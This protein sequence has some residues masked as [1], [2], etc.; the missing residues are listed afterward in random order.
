MEFIKAISESAAPSTLV[1]RRTA[2][3]HYLTYRNTVKR[4][5]SPI[6]PTQLT[7]CLFLI[8]LFQRG[9]TYGTVK[10]YMFSLASELKIRGG[11]NI[12]EPFDSWFI[13]ATLK[14]YRIKIGNKPIRYRRPL[15][16]EVLVSL[17][18]SLDFSIFDNR[19]YGTMA[20]IGF[21]G[22]LRIG[23][24]CFMRVNGVEKSIRMFPVLEVLV[25]SFF[26][27][28]RLT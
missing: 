9:L 10:S 11:K 3:N 1:K 24:L 26:I 17:V 8:Y 22:L 16:T 25:R 23:E 21:Y 7:I 14:H 12:L 15:T 13:R 27:V 5:D 28:Q 4:R 6:C 20:V 2:W 19:V 18:K